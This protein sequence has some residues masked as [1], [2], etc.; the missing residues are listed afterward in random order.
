MTAKSKILFVAHNS[1]LSSSFGGVEAYIN[2]LTKYLSSEYEVF[3]YVPYL[4]NDGVGVQLIGPDIKS[5]KK[6]ILQ[7]PFENWQLSNPE[8]EGAFQKVLQDFDIGLVHFHHLAGHPPSLVRIAK[9]FGARTVFTFH[10]YFSLCHVS[11]LV[12]FEGQYCHPDSIPLSSCDTCLNKKYSILPG[13]QLIRR[14]YWDALFQYLDGLIFNTQGSFD[15]ASKIYTEV[16]SHQNMVILPV[17]IEEVIR[18]KIPPKTSNELRA[19]ILGNLNH[20][21]GADLII[22][23]IEQ[24]AGENISFH[25]FGDIDSAYDEKLALS[26]N[27]QIFKYGKYPSGKL[28]EELFSCDISLHASL[29]PETYS[30]SLSEAWASGLIPIVSNIGALGERVTEGINGLKVTVGSSNALVEAILKINNDPTFRQSLLIQ[31]SSMPISWIGQHAKQLIAY[32]QKLF[33]LIPTIKIIPKAIAM[34]H[35]SPLLIWAFFS[36]PPKRGNSR[37][38]HYLNK[39]KIFLTSNIS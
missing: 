6:I 25:F 13:S 22:E 21:K 32:Y 16:A 35:R 33:F 39:I 7:T 5:V 3:W 27:S 1:V 34:N 18:P 8:R 30:L 20:H 23:A 10:D 17:A 11:N 37:L 28:P 15:L 36:L 24:L 31:A 19:A 14:E 29:C 26:K 38:G 4:G 12:N 9:E 2:M